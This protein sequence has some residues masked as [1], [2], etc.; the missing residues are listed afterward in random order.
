MIVAYVLLISGV[1]L[2]VFSVAPVLVLV[3]GQRALSRE[4]RS[5]IGLSYAAFLTALILAAGW[6]VWLLNAESFPNV[7]GFFLLAAIFASISLGC[8]CLTLSL[9]TAKSAN[10]YWG[11]AATTAKYL[12]WFNSALSVVLTCIAVVQNLS[13]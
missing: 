9:T 11:R 5:R 6:I 13:N 12:F 8:L 2:L 3:K 10:V 1:F 7:N 4:A